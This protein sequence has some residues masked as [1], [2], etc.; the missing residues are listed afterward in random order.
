[1]GATATHIGHL[2]MGLLDFSFP[3]TLKNKGPTG[4]WQDV[5]Q[6]FSVIDL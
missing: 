2:G 3:E 6:Q 5:T 4:M 1:M